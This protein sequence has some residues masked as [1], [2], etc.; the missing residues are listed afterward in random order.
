MSIFKRGN[1]LVFGCVALL[2]FGGCKSA[3]QS[4]VS[5]APTDSAQEAAAVE[6]EDSAVSESALET[7]EANVAETVEQVA[8]EQTKASRS[9]VEQAEKFGATASQDKDSDLWVIEKGASKLTVKEDSRM[10]TLDGVSIWLDSPVTQTRGRWVIGQS[11]EAIVLQSAFGTA[12]APPGINLIVIDP[13]HGGTEDGSKNKGQALV[14]KELNLDLSLR[15]QKHLES[16]G[17]KT[18]LTRYDDRQV[19]LKKRPEIANAAGA[20]LFISVHFNAAQNKDAN[21][22][23][24]YLLTPTGQISTGDTE[25][26]EKEK[27]GYPG[28]RFDLQN[29]QLA[30][31]I[32]KSMIGR[33]KRTDRGVKKARWAV[34]K[35]LDCPGVLVEC[36]FV[37][38]QS[39]AQLVGT[40]GYRERMAMALADAIAAFAGRDTDEKS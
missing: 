27:L 34:L 2:Y 16:L 35:N 23:E 30:Y 37:S 24:T 22:L 36:G 17:F 20:D 15:L 29:F 13:G 18:V 19:D 9:L 8:K 26:S 6:R 3:E 7:D 10:A 4:A 38:N 32:Q 33:L 39:E 11:D 21:G 25:L 14:E 28:N 5:S 31:R 40:A 1:A 12:E